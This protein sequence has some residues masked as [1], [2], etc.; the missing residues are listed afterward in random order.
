[1]LSITIIT[2]INN[3]TQIRYSSVCH[4]VFSSRTSYQRCII[5][6][7]NFSQFHLILGCLYLF[8]VVYFSSMPDVYCTYKRVYRLVDMLVLV[9]KVCIHFFINIILLFSQISFKVMTVLITSV[10][11]RFWTLSIIKPEPCWLAFYLGCLYC[12]LLGT[13]Y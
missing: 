13:L 1:M 10:L 6:V 7:L 3:D 11:R 9:L 5:V 4:Y 12:S 8:K 2:Q